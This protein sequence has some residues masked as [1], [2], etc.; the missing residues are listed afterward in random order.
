[1][2]YS[3]S[4]FK[5]WCLLSY[6]NNWT[7]FFFFAD[8]LWP[9]SRPSKRAWVDTASLMEIAWPVSEIIE[10]VIFSW[11]RSVWPWMKVKVNMINTWCV[12]MSEART[13]QSVMMM[14]SIVSEE[15]LARDTHTQTGRHRQTDRQ[16]DFGLVYLNLFRVVSDF[17]NKTTNH[18]YK[19]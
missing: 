17:E 4:K 1:M 15:S 9:R 18:R 19:N 5:A 16:T 2:A 10:N 3:C 14:T 6:R 13:M 12:T 11:L 8:P 7:L